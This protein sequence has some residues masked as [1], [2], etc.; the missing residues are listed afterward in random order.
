MD[1]DNL[2]ATC[3]NANQTALKRFSLVMPKILLLL[4]PSD[5]IFITSDKH[6]KVEL[7]QHRAPREMNQRHKQ[8]AHV[9]PLS[10]SFL[11]NQRRQFAAS[12]IFVTFLLLSTLDGFT[13]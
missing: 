4:A 3:L 6:P 13:I 9:M 8:Q 7:K 5:F 12:G 10:E 11:C 1:S 2:K